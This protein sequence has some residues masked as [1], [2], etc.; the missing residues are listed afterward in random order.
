MWMLVS[1]VLRII[2]VLINKSISRGDGFEHS[3]GS[4]IV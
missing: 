1:V 4:P 3:P 2:M